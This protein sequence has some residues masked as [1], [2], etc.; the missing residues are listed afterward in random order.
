MLLSGSASVPHCMVTAILAGACLG[1]LPFNANPAKIFMGDTGALF[2]G[3]TLS[4]LSVVGVFKTNM[5]LAFFIP[6]SIFALPLADTAFAVVRRL[7]HGKSPFS[8]DRGHLHHGSPIRSAPFSAFPPR[9]S[10]T[11]PARAARSF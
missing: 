2:L 1:F 3:Y 6:F 5:V 8:P 7:A 4:I 11:I 9:C 10:P